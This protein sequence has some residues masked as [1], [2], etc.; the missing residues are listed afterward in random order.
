[1]VAD[2]N[3]IHLRSSDLEIR[4]MFPFRPRAL[5]DVQLP[6]SIRDGDLQRQLMRETAGSGCSQRYSLRASRGSFGPLPP[7]PPPLH[8]PLVPLVHPNRP[9]DCIQASS[10]TPRYK[11]LRVRLS[12]DGRRNPR[13]IPEAEVIYL[14]AI[15]Q[16][17]RGA[18]DGQS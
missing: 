15:Y 5:F 10:T 14:F 1:V 11:N 9:A 17:A 13:A 12:V 2:R 3:Q 8:P 16:S 18:P 4:H 7:V 6:V